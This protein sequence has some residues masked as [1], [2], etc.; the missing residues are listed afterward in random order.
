[1]V[2]KTRRVP[3]ITAL[4]LVVAGTL[5]LSGCGAAVVEHAGSTSTTT[6]TTTVASTGSDFWDSSSVH[7]ISVDVDADTLA[8]L[9]ET[10]ETS[11]EKEWVEADVVIDGVT[12]PMPG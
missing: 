3:T 9:L 4:S 11:G 6:A 1:M 2:M 5:V 7:T 8:S 10:Y 12:Y